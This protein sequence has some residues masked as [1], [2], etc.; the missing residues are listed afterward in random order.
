VTLLQN[1]TYKTVVEKL[2]YVSRAIQRRMT[3]NGAT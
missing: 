2:D 1:V 3:N